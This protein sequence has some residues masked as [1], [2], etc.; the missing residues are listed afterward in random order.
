MFAISAYAKQFTNPIV[1]SFNPIT[2]SSTGEFK[3]TNVPSARVGGF[4][5]DFRSKLGS[6]LKREWADNIKLGMNASLIFSEADIDSVELSSILSVNP[7]F[8]TTRPF[9]G[10]S[11]YLFNASL[12]YLPPA[13]RMEA[14]LSLN[15][16]GTRLS[17]NSQAGTPDIYEVARPMLNLTFTKWLGKDDKLALKLMVQNLTNANFRRVQTYKDQEFVVSDYQLGQTFSF[18]LTYQIK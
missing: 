3:F 1:R 11:P 18:S 7:D 16:F 6:L 9:Q 12:G 5:L 4:E 14:S 17:E 13:L 10:Q 15:V 2:G 8:G